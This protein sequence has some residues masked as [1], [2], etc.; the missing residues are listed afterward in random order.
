[1][2][3]GA[4]LQLQH[5]ASHK[6]I[7][8]SRHPAV[9]MKDARQVVLDREAGE[10][11]WFRVLPKLRVHSE[12]ERVHVGGPLE[13]RVLEAAAPCARGCSPVC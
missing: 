9:R 10:A 5:E 3:Y 2:R 11:G 8:V 6:Y 13:P 7:C 12:G 4:V 1:M